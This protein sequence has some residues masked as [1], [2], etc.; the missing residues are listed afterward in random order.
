MA[1]YA[2]ILDLIGSLTGAVTEEDAVRS[3]LGL[4]KM[5]FAPGRLVYVPS[6]Q[7]RPG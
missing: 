6:E 3:I 1:D 4:Y 2:M 5:I 7:R